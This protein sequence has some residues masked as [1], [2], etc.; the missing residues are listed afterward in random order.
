MLINKVKR[1]S[2]FPSYLIDNVK[3]I[4]EISIS[5]LFALIFL[6]IYSPYSDTSIFS[7]IKT[8]HF[9]TLSFFVVISSLILILS[10]TCMFFHAKKTVMTYFKFVLWLI[11]EIFI[12]A[13]FHAILSNTYV[14]TDNYSFL[15]ILSKSFLISLIAL[16]FPFTVVNLSFVLAHLRKRLSRKTAIAYLHLKEQSWQKNANIVNFLDN[17]GKLKLSVSIDNLYYIKAVDNY[18]EIF[19]TKNNKLISYVLRC[20]MNTIEELLYNSP[21]IR[22]H[23]SYAINTQKVKVLRNEANGFYVDFDI[24]DITPIPISKTYTENVVKKI[25]N[26]S[27]Q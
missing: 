2:K 23:R 21:I 15:F 26:M 24:S 18:V 17:K 3:M 27:Y 8:N 10:R 1:K 4:I 20:K 19:Y 16:G 5:I 14:I 6:L 7:Q 22:C 13:L 9:I 25:S 11:T 12:I